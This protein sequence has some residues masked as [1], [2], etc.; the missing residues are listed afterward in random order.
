MDVLYFILCMFGGLFII[1]TFWASFMPMMRLD[2]QTG[3]KKFEGDE[4]FHK[5]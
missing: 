1:F 4:Q 3:D 2:P 5:I